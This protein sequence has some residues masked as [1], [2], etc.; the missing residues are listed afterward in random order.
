MALVICYII[1]CVQILGVGFNLWAFDPRILANLSIDRNTVFI[2]LFLTIQAFGLLGAALIFARMRLGFVLSILHHLLLVPAVLI[3]SSRFVLLTDDLVNA[4]LFYLSKPSGS[5]VAFYWS[6][7][8]GPVYEQVTKGVPRG[9]VFIGVNLFALACVIVLWVVLRHINAVREEEAREMEM[10]RR[11]QARRRRQEQQR[12]PQPYPQDDHPQEPY[13]QPQEPY[14]QYEDRQNA[15][16]QRE[17]PQRGGYSQ[18]PQNDYPE[19]PQE[20]QR[21]HPQGRPHAQQQRLHSQP[22]VRMPPRIPP[23]E[24]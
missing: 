14:P 18:H 6:L 19:Y 20:P 16:P 21:M 22:G 13:P 8:W 4:S 12:A 11:Q 17:R 7:G 10:R 3:S 24:S 9:S 2:L 5:S 15:Y 1:A 23:R